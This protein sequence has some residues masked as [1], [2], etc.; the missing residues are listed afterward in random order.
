[1][2]T[3]KLAFLEI[4]NINRMSFGSLTEKS[5]PLSTLIRPVVPPDDLAPY[6]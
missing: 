5:N 3:P 1:M 6:R 4:R 2:L